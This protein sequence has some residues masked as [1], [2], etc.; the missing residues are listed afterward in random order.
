MSQGSDVTQ[1]L[2]FGSVD[3][4]PIRMQQGG[5]FWFTNWNKKFQWSLFAVGFLVFLSGNGCVVG[6][7]HP[8]LKAFRAIIAKLQ[9]MPGDFARDNERSAY[10]KELRELI[11]NFEK[12]EIDVEK[13]RESAIQIVKLFESKVEERFSGNLFSILENHIADLYLKLR[14]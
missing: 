4:Y 2:K 5:Q 6:S 3:T 1:C 12:I 9:D 11:N 13:D 8:K 7:D 14:T 10:N